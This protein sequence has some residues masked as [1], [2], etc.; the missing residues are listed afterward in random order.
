MQ[1]HS[2]MNA[3]HFFVRLGTKSV[4]GREDDP[5]G[6]IFQPAREL[7]VEYADKTMQVGTDK[8]GNAQF[9]PLFETWPNVLAVAI[10]ARG[11]GRPASRR[12]R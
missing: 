11:H 4:I 6:V 8:D 12:T 2:A 10:L 9:A 3:R 1:T 7:Y 5:S